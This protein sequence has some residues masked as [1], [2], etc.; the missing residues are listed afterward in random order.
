MTE[1]QSDR[2]GVEVIDAEGSQRYEARV[3]G[4]LAGIAEYRRRDGRTV[5]T[6]TE[7]ADEFEGQGVGGALA[8]TALDD[9]RAR[10]ER[11]VPVCPFIAEWIERHPD[12][13]DLVDHELYAKLLDRAARRSAAPASAWPSLPWADWADTLETFH[14]WTQVVGK[15]RLVRSPWLNHSWSVP[16]YVAPR[17]LRTSLVPYGTEGFELSFDLIDHRLELTTTT[18]ER[19]E[20]A[21]GP[22]SVAQFHES[23]LAMMADVGMPVSIHP[24]PSELPDAVPFPED[25]AHASYDPA[26][27]GAIWR[28]LVQAERVMTRFRAG[29]LGKA[30]PVHLFWGAFDLA[31]TRFSGR[32]APPHAGGMPNFPDDVAREAYSHEVTSV[33]L[34]FGNRESPTPVFY[35]YAYPTPDGFSTAEVQPDAAFWLDALGEF[36]LPYDAVAGADDPDEL[37]LSFFESAHDAAAEL[38]GWARDELEC[39]HPMGPDWW[40]TR[41]TA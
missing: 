31:T 13:D 24:V 7:V 17:G 25:H 39:A 1:Q 30:S 36:V 37:L 41:P 11:V 18:G 28:A 23:V 21:L 5:F 22:M 26:Q 2:P 35:A 12:Y 19:R 3:G 29:Y 20:L 38:A 9:V 16:L 27:V 33:G 32:T 15:I 34:W 4:E 10:G 14:L 6:H 8:R 40:V